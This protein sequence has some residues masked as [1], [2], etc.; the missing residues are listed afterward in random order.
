M[1]ESRFALDDPSSPSLVDSV[2]HSISD[3]L[4]GFDPVVREGFKLALKT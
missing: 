1:Y 4:S 2:L 3:D